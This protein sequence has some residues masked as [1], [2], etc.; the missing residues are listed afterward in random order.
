[1][2]D[3]RNNRNTEQRQQT[4]EVRRTW[5]EQ[6]DNDQHGG[7][8]AGRNDDDD[9]R[10]YRNEG[11]RSQDLGGQGQE[12]EHRLTRGRYRTE[13]PHGHQQAYG[14][15]PDRNFSDRD[16]DH[17]RNNNGW[18]EHRDDQGEQPRSGYRGG[19]TSYGGHRAQGFGNEGFGTESYGNRGGYGE[20]GGN[21]N[22]G[23]YGN[24]GRSDQGYGTRNGYG[25]Q[26][27]YGS[28]RQQRNWEHR[29]ESHRNDER[30]QTRYETRPEDRYL[31]DTGRGFGNDQYDDRSWNDR[32]RDEQ[33]NEASGFAGDHQG[34]YDNDDH[35]GRD[36]NWNE[37]QDRGMRGYPDEHLGRQG[38]RSRHMDHRGRYSNEGDRYYQGDSFYNEG[39]Y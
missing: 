30:Y 8:Q 27:A 11:R 14:S 17:G 26:R 18:N 25:D 32:Q 2:S 33:R 10:P 20:R 3:N 15:W 1:M 22:R 13:Q 35:S 4:S 37:G 7:Y 12:N 36:R 39:R 19:N 29:N 28:G 9:R 31:A 5:N 21:G 23:G 24:E 34:A 6:N 38:G 16:R